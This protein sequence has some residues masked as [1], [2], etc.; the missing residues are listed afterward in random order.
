MVKFNVHKIK[1]DSEL[2]Y[3]KAWLETASLLKQEGRYPTLQ[4]KRK[5]HD[6]NSLIFKVRNTL[7]DIGFTKTIVPVMIEKGEVYAQYGPERVIM[8]RIFFLAGLARPD[9]GISDKK[10]EE[11]K[12]VVPNF[13]GTEL[14]EFSENTR[15]AKSTPTTWSK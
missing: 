5:E 8:D 7:L 14:R 13:A 3:E 6:L 1:K 4:N 9:I 15:K 10:L 2:D 11:V 12:A